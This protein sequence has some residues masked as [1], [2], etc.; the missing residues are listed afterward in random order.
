MPAEF[1]R[2]A[3]HDEQLPAFVGPEIACIGRSNVGKSSLLNRL[4]KTHQ[5]VR[6]S[7]T[8][9]RTQLLNVFQYEHVFFV[10]LPGYGYAKMSQEGRAGMDS[11]V[12]NYFKN[13]E[14]LSAVWLLID[15]RHPEGMDRDASMV[16]WFRAHNREFTLIF[17][18]IDCVSKTKRLI[19]VRKLEQFF[20]VRSGSALLFSAKTGE[21]R[22]KLL[23]L[24]HD[25]KKTAHL[26]V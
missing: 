8:P 16:S 5:L 18:K 15:A 22:D 9:G 25:L 26:G 2:S 21:G 20:S 14:N 10:D 6:T 1:V 13:R 23:K 7:K 3:E 11:R 4:F 12:E 19:H 24:M 17:T